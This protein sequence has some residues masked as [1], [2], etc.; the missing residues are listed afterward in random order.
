[1]FFIQ[2][3]CKREVRDIQYQSMNWIGYADIKYNFLVGGDGAIYV[4]RGWDIECQ[5]AAGC[6]AKSIFIA[7]I[8][9]F[10]DEVPPK[11]Q[12]DAAQKLIK[13]CVNLNKLSSFYRL[14]GDDQLNDIE[15]PDKMIYKIIRK[16]PHWT[17]TNQNTTEICANNIDTITNRKFPEN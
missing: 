2:S 10:E 13:E 8:G 11:Q 3:D 4:G 12:I 15:S 1:M 14:Y 16:W 7:F 5:H 6:S 17:D 9:T